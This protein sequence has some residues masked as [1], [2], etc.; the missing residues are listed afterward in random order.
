MKIIELTMIGLIIGGAILLLNDLSILSNAAPGGGGGQNYTLIDY[1]VISMDLQPD[2][3]YSIRWEYTWNWRD[4]DTKSIGTDYF[5]PA[6]DTKMLEEI[7]KRTNKRITK[8]I[9]NTLKNEG[10]SKPP[11]AICGSRRSPGG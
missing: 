2:G 8:T 3:N 9:E 10:R 5:K 4:T 1:E 6:T 7:E 11:C